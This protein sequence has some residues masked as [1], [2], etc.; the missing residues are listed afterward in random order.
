M[1]DSLVLKIFKFI[2]II[3]SMLLASMGYIIEYAVYFIAVI[4]GIMILFY[5]IYRKIES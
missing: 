5:F 3:E 1:M 4:L 2:L